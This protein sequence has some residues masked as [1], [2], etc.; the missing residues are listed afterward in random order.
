ITSSMRSPGA[1]A[2]FS[3]SRMVIAPRSGAGTSTR[4]PRYLPMGVRTAERIS[5]SVILVPSRIPGGCV[6]YP[7]CT[8]TALTEGSPARAADDWSHVRR[9]SPAPPPV[10]EFFKPWLAGQLDHAAVGKQPDGDV[11]V[12][13]V[14][15]DELLGAFDFLETMCPVLDLLDPGVADG[16]LEV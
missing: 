13:V 15:L 9:W 7:H 10:V 4:E 6:S 5:A 16:V 1:P 14:Q 2:R 3:A 8:Q 11:A 12:L